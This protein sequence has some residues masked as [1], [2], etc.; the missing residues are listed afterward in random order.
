MSEINNY[1]NIFYPINNNSA[2]IK[3]MLSGRMWEK[4]IVSIFHEYIT[5]DDTVLDVGSYIG[6]HMVEMSKLAN[7]VYSFEPVPL[8]SFESKCLLGNSI[9]GS[10]KFAEFN[11]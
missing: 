3:S 7:R 5:Q 4:K 2:V 11:A 8:I 9:V 10:G 6:T 1:G